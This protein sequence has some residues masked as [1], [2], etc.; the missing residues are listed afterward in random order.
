MIVL[1]VQDGAWHYTLLARRELSG[2]LR[3]Q[4]SLHLNCPMVLVSDSCPI[5]DCLQWCVARFLGCMQIYADLLTGFVA[6]K[7]SIASFL[8]VSCCGAHGHLSEP[9]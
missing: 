5:H 6:L 9:S 7:S 8:K 3:R 4:I 2:E 1:F